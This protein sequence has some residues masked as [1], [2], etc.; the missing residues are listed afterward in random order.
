MKIGDRDFEIGKRTYLM[1][2]LNV[3]PDSF[4]DS[5]KYYEIESAVK[6]AREMVEQG[7]DIIDIGGESTRPSCTAV[8]ETEELN[9]VIPIIRAIKATMNI[10]ISIDT[11]KS[12]V[13]EAALLNGASMVN[14]IWG[15]KYDN[16]MAK[17]VA[18]YNVPC[19]LNHNSNLVLSQ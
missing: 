2:I 1:G 15:F 19:C 4:S 7:A 6:R 16:N 5:G 8:S 11:Y 13:A 17:I 12:S 9:R 14:D 10:P 3:T 18:K